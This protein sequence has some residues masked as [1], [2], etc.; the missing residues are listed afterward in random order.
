MLSIIAWTMFFIGPAHCY[1]YLKCKSNKSIRQYQSLL[2]LA[3][4]LPKIMLLFAFDGFSSLYNFDIF[5]YIIANCIGNLLDYGHLTFLQSTTSLLQSNIFIILLFILKTKI[6]QL[7][8][9]LLFYNHDFTMLI[10]VL[11]SYF[12]DLQL[13][14]VLLLNVITFLQPSSH[15]NTYIIWVSMLFLVMTC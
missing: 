11:L 9:L 10:L 4:I 13:T 2:I 6:Y 1:C 14:I 8:I 5:C 12:Y 7:L 3:T 15:Y